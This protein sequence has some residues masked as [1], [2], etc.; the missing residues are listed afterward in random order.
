MKCYKSFHWS[1]NGS[2]GS[3]ATAINVVHISVTLKDDRSFRFSFS[4]S[5]I[6]SLCRLLFVPA[7]RYFHQEPVRQ[8]TL[9]QV[10]MSQMEG[11]Y[12]APENEE[13][14]N[15]FMQLVTLAS[16]ICACS[17]DDEKHTAWIDAS[18]CV[19]SW[20]ATPQLKCFLHH[21]I[22]YIVPFHKPYIFL[23]PAFN[24]SLNISVFVHLYDRF[25][26]SIFCA[27]TE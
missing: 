5:P 9:L 6:F 23:S 2:E 8:N 4:P 13:T 11:G 10:K 19:Q 3:K 22:Y 20:N 14:L 24:I 15:D 21:T 18:L 25:T 1:T 17:N 27:Q 12:E 26:L 16:S 7:R